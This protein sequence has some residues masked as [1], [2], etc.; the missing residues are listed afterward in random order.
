LETNHRKELNYESDLDADVL[1]ACV[2][3]AGWV[4]AV[5][6]VVVRKRTTRREGTMSSYTTNWRNRLAC[7]LFGHR[8]YVQLNFNSRARKLGCHRCKGAW[9][10][11][12]D[13]KQ[14]LVR[15]DEDFHRHAQLTREM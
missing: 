4:G 1:Q 15:W 8:F 11:Y 12:D 3:G 9:A 14:T 6:R 10:M 13:P 2:D 7:F 5:G